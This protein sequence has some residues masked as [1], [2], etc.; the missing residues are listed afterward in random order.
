MTTP[1]LSASV[2]L[3]AYT[4]HRWSGIVRAVASVHA[5]TA[6]AHEVLLVVDHNP[7]L[8]ARA[9]TA[10]TG[11][12]VVENTYRTGLSGARNTGFHAATGEVVAF[13]DDDAAARPDWL[14][15][16]LVMYRD[17]TVMG[18][19]GSA[20]PVWP[21]GFDR[22]AFLPADDA[23][24]GTGELDWVVGCTYSGLPTRLA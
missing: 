22:P 14:E 24:I 21:T 15:R 7:D 5:Q 11:V 10:L 17:P 8:A 2:V 16:L 19:G 13:I 9:R 23:G 6:P 1:I 4:D 12:I 3:C 18:V 20:R